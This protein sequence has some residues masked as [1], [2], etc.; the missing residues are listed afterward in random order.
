MAKEI[1]VIGIIPKYPKHSQYNVYSKVRMPPVGIVSVLSQIN[2]DRRFKEVYVIDE[3]NYMGPRDFLGMP[4]HNFLQKRNPAKIAMLYGG[5][6]NSIPRMFSVA[7]QYKSFGAI[8]IAGGSHVTALPEEALNSGVDIV[9]HGEGEETVKDILDV[10]IKNG[11]VE[12]NKNDLVHIKGISI[13]DENGKY[14]FTGKREPIKDLDKLNDV[15]LTLIKFLEKRWSAIPVNRGRGCNWDCEFCVVNKQYG[16]YKSM[17]NEKALKQVIK[18]SDL[19]YGYFFFTD[20]NFA[21]NIKEATELC[22]MIGDYK[23]KFHKKIHLMVQVR[24]EIADNNELIDAMRY[25]GVDTLAI[26]YESPINEELKSMKKGVTVEKLTERSKKLSNYFYLHGMF[27]F[28][29]PSFKDSKYKSN[30]TLEQKAEAYEKFFKNAKIDT[31][32]V[33]NALPL[34]GSDLRVKLEAEKRI[35]PLEMIGWDKYDG[36][37]LCYDPRPEGVDAYDL[38]NITRRL[39][40]KWYLG[41]FIDM[42]LNY[43]KWM[44]WTYNATIGFPIQFGTFYVKRIVHNFIEKQRE[45]NITK[46]VSLLP[47]K[48]IFYKS[49]INSWEDIKREWRNLF[50]KT[51]GSGVVRKWLNEYKKS[52]YRTKLKEF[53]KKKIVKQ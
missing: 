37:F 14:L 5:M 33:L 38:Q 29:Y 49:F 2:N 7:K 42:G 46:Q 13:L 23:R 3:N 51:Y 4:D 20:D 6:S 19:G 22:K 39:M 25:A 44:N 12:L 11:D 45:K 16:D 28:N 34:P 9:V 53:F 48:N 36:M 17:S 27:I 50:V 30:L 35:L 47:Q 43:G 1:S 32:Q 15:D 31:V 40:K 52:D 26:G 24:S 18:Y 21:Q 10:I 41:N 8:T